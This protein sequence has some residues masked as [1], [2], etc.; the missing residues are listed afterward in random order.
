MRCLRSNPTPEL[1]HV[2]YELIN[3]T[4]ALVAARASGVFVMEHY[5]TDQIS[6]TVMGV[7]SEYLKSNERT[8][9]WD[10]NIKANVDPFEGM[11][12]GFFAADW[13]LKVGS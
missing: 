11:E 3:T 6:T 12:C 5:S 7:L 10:D 2:A 8:I 4:R 1:F 9:F 13:D